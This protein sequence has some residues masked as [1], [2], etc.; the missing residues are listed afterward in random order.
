MLLSRGSGHDFGPEHAQRGASTTI[1]HV[2][3]GL[4]LFSGCGFLHSAHPSP[5]STGRFSRAV[6][7]DGVE[8]RRRKQV[9]KEVFEWV[10]NVLRGGRRRDEFVN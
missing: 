1:R 5:R 7:K 2:T 4:V 3:Q 10:I 8:G 6:Y 9:L